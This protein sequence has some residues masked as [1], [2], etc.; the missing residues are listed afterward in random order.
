MQPHLRSVPGPTDVE[1]AVPDAGEHPRSFEGFYEA[2]HQRLF[3]ALCLVTGNRDEAEEI[4]QDAFLRIF[5]R[6]NKVSS[7]EDLDGYLFRTAMNVFRNRYRRTVVA[8][9]RVLSPGAARDDLAAVETRDEVVRLLRTLNPRQRAAVVLTSILDYSS[10]E[11]GRL[12]KIRASTVRALT[13]QA[14][15]QL[16]QSAEEQR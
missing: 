6:W 3:T 14:R 9:R 8:A 16:K 13:T 15:A 7:V 5:E 4:M 1:A 2:S 12:L 10:E 11:A